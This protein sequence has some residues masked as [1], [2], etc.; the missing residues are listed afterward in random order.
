MRVALIGVKRH[1]VPVCQGKLLLRK[2]SDG[3]K[4]LV[5]G[6]A[7]RHGQHDVVHQFRGPTRRAAVGSAVEMDGMVD[8]GAPDAG[9]VGFG[10]RILVAERDAEQQSVV[11]GNLKLI[12]HDVGKQP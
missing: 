4:Q 3:L 10:L 5:R 2:L 11:G 1:G 8:F 6:S 12:A 7:R 9:G